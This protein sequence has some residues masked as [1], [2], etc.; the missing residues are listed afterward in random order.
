MEMKEIVEEVEVMGVPRL[1]LPSLGGGGGA[2]L[3]VHTSLLSLSSLPSLALPP[4][5]AL[6][7]RRRSGEFVKLGTSL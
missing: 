5:Y 7:V 6:W 3:V 2:A 4:A 1:W